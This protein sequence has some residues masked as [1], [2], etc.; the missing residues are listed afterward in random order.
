[1]HLYLVLRSSADMQPCQTVAQ[2]VDLLSQLLHWLLEERECVLRDR[3]MIVGCFLLEF[4]RLPI[5]FVRYAVH[6]CLL[7]RAGEESE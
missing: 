6:L 7:S 3:S 1:M 5:A 4:L 2:N